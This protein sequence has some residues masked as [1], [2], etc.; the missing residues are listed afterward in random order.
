MESGEIRRMGLAPGS[1]NKGIAAPSI[2]APSISA[3]KAACKFTNTVGT[4]SARIRSFIFQ[5]R[6]M[7]YLFKTVRRQV[8]H[9]LD[10]A[11]VHQPLRAPDQ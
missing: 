4:V 6:D 10:K 7:T 8:L 1:E 3:S 9:D 5:P 11:L 2:S